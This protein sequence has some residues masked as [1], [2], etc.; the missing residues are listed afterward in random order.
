MT[1]GPKKLLNMALLLAFM[2][3][4]SLFIYTIDTLKRTR[5]ELELEAFYM[6]DLSNCQ[7]T[8][9]VERQYPSRYQLF[10]TNCNREYYPILLGKES[11]YEDYNRFDKG[12]IVNK[13][14]NSLNLFLKDSLSELELMIRHPSD[15]DD[16]S[17]GITFFWI[18]FGIVLLIMVFIPN[19][20]WDNY[21][22]WE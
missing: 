8:D 2:V 20:F 9:L 3:F 1:I 12:L 14:A 16:R 15:E 7:I 13:E 21:N 5:I 22:F 18:F 17:L 11:N 19:S 4:G 6:A 10:R